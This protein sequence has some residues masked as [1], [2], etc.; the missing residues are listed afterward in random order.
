MEYYYCSS[1]TASLDGIVIDGSI[2]LFDGT[3][4]HSYDTV[5]PGACDELVDLGRFW[6][7]RALAHKAG[8]IRALGEKKKRAYKHAYAYLAAAGEVREALESIISPV[9]K[10]EKMSAVI[11][12]ICETDKRGD[13][14]IAVRQ[15]SAFG[16]SGAVRLD[17]LTKKAERM[18]AVEDY[19]GAAAIFMRQLYD[20]A[21]ECGR[22]ME[23]SFDTL[24]V[25]TPREIYFADSGECFAVCDTS[26][27][28]PE[29][30]RRIKMKRFIDGEGLTHIRHSYRTARNTQRD[31]CDLAA[32]QLSEAGRAHADMEKI[33]VANMNFSRLQGFCAEFLER[34]ELE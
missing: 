17:T 19:Y 11:R 31:L 34:L 7:A 16:T 9:V 13:G 2:A 15:V 22:T 6:D 21:V 27:D 24:D 18:C 25:S 28:I 23:V 1:D 14:R 3:A 12:R 33:Y 29:A 32:H 30:E 8:S 20:R 5:L 10:W 4:P 26:C